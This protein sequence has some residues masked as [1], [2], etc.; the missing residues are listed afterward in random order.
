MDVRQVLAQ[1]FQLLTLSFSKQPVATATATATVSSRAA[2][3]IHPPA[4]V[5]YEMPPLRA[6]CMVRRPLLLA[7]PRKAL[8]Q[9]PP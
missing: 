5:F 6:A 8:Q 3:A 4:Q 2:G 9:L 1:L 7:S